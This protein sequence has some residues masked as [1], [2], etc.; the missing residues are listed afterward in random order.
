M[1]KGLQS[2]I[3]CCKN[4]SSKD[5]LK[6]TGTLG[7]DYISKMKLDTRNEMGQIY[8]NLELT[9]VIQQLSSCEI[10]ASQ[11]Q[12]SRK[13]EARHLVHFYHQRCSRRKGCH[14]DL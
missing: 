9:L 14:Q 11:H 13:Y 4:M 5:R 12:D 3:D 7:G 2:G 10:V 8:E 1:H 6:L